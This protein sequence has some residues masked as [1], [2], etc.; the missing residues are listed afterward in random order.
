[1]RVALFKAIE[2][3]MWDLIWGEDLERQMSQEEVVVVVKRILSTTPVR[4]DRCFHFTNKGWLK[5]TPFLL[6]AEK[7]NLPL[8]K[9]LAKRPDTD[10]RATSRGGNN[11]YA[12]CKHAMMR[13]RRSDRDIANSKV[14]HYLH[15][16]C[17]CNQR[18]YRWE[19]RG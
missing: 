9:Y 16:E 19:G 5:Y 1:V 13:N 8:V 6:A 12:I 15:T 14:L 3:R 7:H 11:A 18:P 2:A 10:L 4:N 17:W